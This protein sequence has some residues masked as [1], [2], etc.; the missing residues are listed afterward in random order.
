[1]DAQATHSEIL[2]YLGGGLG[3]RGFP[4]DSNVQPEAYVLAVPP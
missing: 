1:M 3:L 2:I 4:G